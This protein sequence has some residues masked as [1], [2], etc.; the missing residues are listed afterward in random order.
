MHIIALGW[1]YVV[2]MMAFTEKTVLAGFMT[3]TMYCALPL[4][5]VWFIVKRKKPAPANDLKRAQPDE[6][7]NASTQQEHDSNKT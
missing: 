5:I 4:G 2:S 6:P 1:I 3:F 7:V